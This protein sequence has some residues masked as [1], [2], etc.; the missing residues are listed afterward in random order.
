MTIAELS[1]KRPVTAIMFFVSMVVIG[2]IAAVRLPLEQFPSLDAPFLFVQIPYPGSTPTEIER[3]ITRPVEEALATLPGIKRM[4]STSDAESAQIFLEFKWGESTAIKA[5]QAREKIDAIR[6]DLPSDLQRYTVLKFSTS[7]DPILKLRIATE[8]GVDISNAYDLLDHEIKRPLER[9]PGVARVDLQG[10]GKPEVQ[11]ELSSDRLSAHNINLNDLYT[12]LQAA[13]FSISAGQVS[14]GGSRFRVQPQGQ[15]ASLDDIRGIPLD[16]KGL[17]LGDIATVTLRPERLNYAR[18]LDGRPA[19]GFDIYRERTANLVDVGTQVLEEI[20]RIQKSP[21]L[22]GVRVFLLDNQAESVTGSL[23]ELGKAGLEGTLLSVLVLFF[24]LRDWPSTLMVSLSIPICLVIT[25]GCMYF[26]GISLNVLSMMGLLL[27]VGMLVDNAVV[28][29]ESIYQYREKNPGKPW[30]SAVQGTQVVGIAI[31]AGTLTSMIVFLPNIFGE[32]NDISIFLAQ[33]AIAMSIAHLASWL[34]AVSLVPML[35]AKLPPPKFL[36]RETMITRMRERYGRLIAWTLAHRRITM[37][38]VVALLLASFVPIILTKKD[39]FDS[40]ESRRLYLRYELNANYRLQ[41][42]KP[43]VAQVE[44]FLEKNRQRF[45]IKSMYTYYNEQGDATTS[46][47]LTDADQAKRSA[48]D[49]K[50]DM[51]KEFP[52]LAVGKL[53]FDFRSSTGGGV[54]LSLIGDSM[55]QLREIA[56]TVVSVL[57]RLPTLKDVRTEKGNGDREVATRVDRVRAKNYGFDAQSVANYIQ[58]ALRGMPLKDFHAGDRQLPVWLRFQGADTQS[59]AGLSDFKLRAPD[60]TQIPLLSLMRADARDTPT[61]IQ[62]V[63]RLTALKI[64]ANLA[65]GKTMPEARDEITKAMNAFA[66]PPGYRW[67]FGQGFDRDQDAGAQMLFNTL[68]ALVLVY[69]VMCAM[70]E[71]LVFPAAILT[72]FIFS[73]FGVFWLFW[74]TGTTFSIMAFIGILILM[75]VVVNNGIVMIVHI[76]QLR[77]EGH[78][79]TEALVLGAKERLRPVLMTMATAILGML[80][81]AIGGAEAWSDGPPYS[82]MARAIAGGLTFSTIVTLLALPCIYSLL[83]DARTWARHVLRDARP[84]GRIETAPALAVGAPSSH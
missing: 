59:L 63:D 30:Y 1:L 10:V 2:L 21:E 18:S 32:A 33:V 37:A 67:T 55:D 4:N 80:P 83:D 6:A 16:A 75:G 26:F 84:S 28:V 36:G 65:E 41:D 50:E 7:D 46:I 53:S 39:M 54:D 15:W 66:L 27:A 58:I 71:S 45:E 8:S 52:V 25:L 74:L 19:I 47:M 43:A 64:T 38:G 5:V 82:P 35:S 17:R 13:N 73:V 81:L 12:R 48:I 72:T 42:L 14:S 49:I 20:G 11:I 76:N 34:V 40:G 31:A 9:I 51:R 79:R 22:H 68:I 3:T 70:F 44:A 69:V 60:G 56:P 61:A 23:R 57:S 24:F 77:Y 62:R 78:L 29:V